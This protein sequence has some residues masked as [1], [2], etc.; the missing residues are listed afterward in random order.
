MGG[1]SP[2]PPF[3]VTSHYREE[4]DATDI[5]EN[6][7]PE[8]LPIPSGVSNPRHS[9]LRHLFINNIFMHY[10]RMKRNIITIIHR[11]AVYYGSK[12]H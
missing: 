9:C 8:R 5:E 1:R 12:C 11:A 3:F 4:H 6:T 7:S 2:V 10:G